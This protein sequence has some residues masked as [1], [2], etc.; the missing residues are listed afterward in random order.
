MLGVVFSRVDLVSARV[1]SAVK[2]LLSAS[3]TSAGS[4]RVYR[5]RDSVIIE[6]ADRDLVFLDDLDHVSR[7][8]GVDHLLF[9]SRHEM[10]RPR[11]MFTVHVSGNWSKAELGGRDEEVSLA[12][13]HFNANIFR[14]LH[15]LVGERGLDHEFS[16]EIEATHHG[17]SLTTSA[18]TFL[19][20]GSSSRE[21]SRDDCIKLVR[22][23]VISALDSPQ[24]YM[25]Y[26]GAPAISIGDLHYSTIKDMVVRGEIALGHVI[27]KYVS[28][29]RRCIEMSV[30]RNI[31]KPVIAI[32]HWKSIERETRELVVR[33]LRERGVELVRRG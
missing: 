9:V 10:S 21:W 19:E 23:V 11:P 33:C 4:Y 1:L 29:T 5:Y 15:R 12:S 30:D 8:L 18:I 16:C 26:A 24:D 31:V 14:L 6:S 27:P 2:S 13:P 7:K 3:S 22:D 32:V 25:T 20:L 28:I 17:P